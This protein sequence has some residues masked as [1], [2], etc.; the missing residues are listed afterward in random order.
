MSDFNIERY[1]TASKHGKLILSPSFQE[2]HF[3][4]HGVDCPFPFFEEGEFYMT[5]IAW[6]GIGYRTAL[7][8]SGDLISWRDLGILIDRGPV[9]SVTEFNV[10]MTSIMREN[11][12]FGPARLKMVDGRYVGTY[13]AYPKPGYEQ[14]PAAIGLCFSNDLKE[15]VVEEPVLRPEQTAIW[16]AGGLYKSW[17]MEHDGKFYLFYNAKD[18]IPG[19]AKEQ[20]GVAVSDDLKNW[21]RNPLNPL[22]RNGA[23]GEFDDIFASDPAV[24]FDDGRWLLF[25]FGN[26]SDG[27]ARNS[28]AYS[29]DLLNWEKSGEI[30]IDVGR[31]GELDSVYAHKPGLISH[32]GRLFHFYCA[33]RSKVSSDGPLMGIG[34]VRG[35][36]FATNAGVETEEE[37][38]AAVGCAV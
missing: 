11:A 16:E 36:T 7:A 30:L 12:L 29:Y 18:N 1:V 23:P 24:F 4:S 28:V 14:G 31:K 8:K 10:A 37:H 34:E 3:R 5:Y 22:V 35:I 33:V 25:Y 38:L 27:F 32:Q 21:T 20:I 2:G 19:S 13:H 26:S 17:I 15:W 6:D 9:G